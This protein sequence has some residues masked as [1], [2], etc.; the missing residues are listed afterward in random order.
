MTIKVWFYWQVKKIMKEIKQYH[1]VRYDNGEIT[2]EQT[3]NPTDYNQI[4]LFIMGALGEYSKHLY[5]E[6]TDGTR[7]EIMLIDERLYEK[8]KMDSDDVCYIPSKINKE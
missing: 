8:V 4:G 5:E 2:D 7:Y 6:Y 3:C 1:L